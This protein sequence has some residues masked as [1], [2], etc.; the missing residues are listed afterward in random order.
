MLGTC[1]FLVIYQQA[2]RGAARAGH[3]HSPATFAQAAN[4]SMACPIP[5][6]DWGFKTRAAGLC[7]E[8]LPPLV[9]T[10]QTLSQAPSYQCRT[11]I[12]AA[13]TNSP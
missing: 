5:V 7:P 3:N 2:K 13:E 6:G 11:K 9:D 8:S 12:Q 10:A 1:P 4:F